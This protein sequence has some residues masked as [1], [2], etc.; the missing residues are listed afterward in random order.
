MS[1]AEEIRN[2]TRAFK[3]KVLLETNYRSH[4][5][6]IFEISLKHY[7]MRE[8]KASIDREVITDLEFQKRF[9]GIPIREI[10]SNSYISATMEGEDIFFPIQT[11]VLPPAHNT[12]GYEYTEPGSAA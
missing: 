3:R 9:Y 6:L 10:G 12:D 8:L 1:Y 7:D 2:A 11:E 5:R 4:T